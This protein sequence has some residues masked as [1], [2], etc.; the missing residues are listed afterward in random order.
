MAKTEEEK[1]PTAGILC[2][3]VGFDAANVR[4]LEL[5][6]QRLPDPGRLPAAEGA[7]RDWTSIL[8]KS[9]LAKTQLNNGWFGSGLTALID[10]YK[11]QLRNRRD[12][13]KNF[14]L[15]PRKEWEASLEKAKAAVANLH[16]KLEQAV[17]DEFD[18]NIKSEDV[19]IDLAYNEIDKDIANW[20]KERR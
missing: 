1:D 15:K 13:K 19:A 17:E 9:E 16:D 14:R 4:L 5:A 8:K 2:T 12:E 10:E 3:L 6:A 7:V 18:L 20:I 11:K